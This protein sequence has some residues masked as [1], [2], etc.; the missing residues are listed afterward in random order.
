MKPMRCLPS[1]AGVCPEWTGGLTPRSHAAW[2]TATPREPPLRGCRRVIGGT[3]DV[4]ELDRRAAGGEPRLTGTTAG[5]DGGAAAVLDL[6]GDRDGVGG[7]LL[8]EVGGDA[9]ENVGRGVEDQL[10]Q[11][12]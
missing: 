5:I 10:T 8:E 2:A 11:A 7:R 1:A 12:G 6:R 4:V 9:G 3:P